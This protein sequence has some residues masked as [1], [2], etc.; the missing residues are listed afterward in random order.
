MLDTPNNQQS[1]DFSRQFMEQVVPKNNELRR[2]HDLVDFSFVYNELK[3]KY[4]KIGRRAIDPILLFKYL[5][6]KELFDISDIDV[7]NRSLYDMSFKY[8][9][10]LAHDEVN[11]INPSTLTK[12]RR[13]RLIDLDLLNLLITKTMEVAVSNG[14][15]LSKTGIVDA[16]HTESKYTYEYYGRK[17]NKRMDKLF[18]LIKKFSPE[19][20]ESM[21]TITGSKDEKTV[22]KEAEAFVQMLEEKAV[23]RDIPA[24]TEALNNLKET[25]DDAKED[26]VI[27]SKDKDAQIG[28][29]SVRRSFFGYKTHLLL[30][31]NRLIKAA[32][33][34]P[35]KTDDGSELPSLIQQCAD[36]DLPLDAIIGD[37]AYSAKANLDL[38]KENDIKLF[39]RMNPTISQGTRTQE[40]QFTYCKD[41][42]GF[43]CPA[44]H[45]SIRKERHDRKSSQKYY[46]PA[47]RYYF[48]IAKCKV[49]PL[50]DGCYKEGAKSKCYQVRIV[51]GI[52]K[53]HI[54]FEKTDEFNEQMRE[55]YKVEAKNG[56][57]KNQHGYNKTRSYGL[58]SM[59]IQ[60]AVA[61]SVVNLKRILR[62]MDQNK[63][64]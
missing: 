2:L 36:R 19:D 30:D 37:R 59:T 38:A 49:C 47:V 24:V 13:Q 35:G 56:E 29:K 54:E 17:L 20:A 8:F 33:I 42:D 9:L 64:K 57:L 32:T 44:G 11:L 58:D 4:S 40:R 7:V 14:I 41:G 27:A 18:S 15:K 10:G 48:D 34:T 46:S 28:H 61:I 45:L 63:R 50:R 21:P 16:T 62:L 51:E 39:A 31:P 1:I 25:L 23:I 43:I 55:R 12:F 6:L 22:R 26:G 5:F 53:E 3:D 52:F 60:G